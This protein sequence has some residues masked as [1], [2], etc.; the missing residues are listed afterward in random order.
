MK[1]KQ[2]DLILF[3]MQTYHLWEYFVEGF[4]R[5]ICSRITMQI[6]L[7]SRRKEVFCSM[8]SSLGINIHFPSTIRYSLPNTTGALW[9]TLAASPTQTPM[10]SNKSQQCHFPTGEATLISMNLPICGSVTSWPWSGGTTYGSKKVLQHSFPSTANLLSA[11]KHH[12]KKLIVGA[13]SS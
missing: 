7:S 8:K 5:N 3:R 6:W 10:S 13:V 9:K 4:W 1:W 2:Q 12:N 11:R